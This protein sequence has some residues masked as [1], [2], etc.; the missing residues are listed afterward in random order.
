MDKSGVKAKVN[1]GAA[2]PE[3]TGYSQAIGYYPAF[4]FWGVK[5]RSF[6][7]Q[8]RFFNDKTG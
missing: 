5:R 4:G 1:R 6:G 2:R 3:W 8:V 7:C